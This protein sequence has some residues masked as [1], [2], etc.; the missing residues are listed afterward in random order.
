MYLGQRVV[1]HVVIF[2]AWVDIS[3]FKISDIKVGWGA[4]PC[5]PLKLKINNYQYQYTANYH[6]YNQWIVIVKEINNV[7]TNSWLILF[8]AFIFQWSR[9]N[10]YQHSYWF[11]WFLDLWEQRTSRARCEHWITQ[12]LFFVLL[13]MTLI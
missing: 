5:L 8:T 4:T 12:E 13:T 10:G 9:R 6:S 11:E 3:C 1:R 7:K 2:R